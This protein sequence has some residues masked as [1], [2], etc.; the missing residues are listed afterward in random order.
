MFKRIE[1]GCLRK[2]KKFRMWLEECS[3]LGG[4]VLIAGTGSNC[5]LINPNGSEA[6]CGGWGHLI[7]DESSGK[8]NCSFDMFLITL[9]VFSLSTSDAS[10]GSYSYSL[11]NEYAFTHAIFLVEI[12]FFLK[13]NLWFHSLACFQ[14]CF[15]NVRVI[16]C[17]KY[18]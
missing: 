4:I 2:Y 7:G 9:T 16:W 13:K 14:V 5:H 12:S 6:R 18:Q 1:I 15:K 17:L 8:T 11:L 3:L 10:T